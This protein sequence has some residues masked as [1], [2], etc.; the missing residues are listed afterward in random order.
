M[1]DPLTQAETQNGKRCLRTGCLDVWE[2][3]FQNLGVFAAGEV[4]LTSCHSRSAHP[5]GTTSSVCVFPSVCV[6]VCGGGERD[7]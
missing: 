4:A 3:H 2:M 7:N 1:T 5:R 6:C